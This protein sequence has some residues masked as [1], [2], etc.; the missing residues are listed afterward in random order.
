MQTAR[1]WDS[2]KEALIKVLA[3]FKPKTVLEWGPGVSTLIMQDFP[4][5][6][7]IDT[8]E[9]NPAWWA[10]WKDKFGTKVK[11]Y[12]EENLRNYPYVY[13]GEFKYDLIFVDG[14][15]RE[16][17]LVVAQG[18]IKEDGIVILHDAERESYKS[19]IDN[20]QFVFY[21]DDGH[22]SIMTKSVESN[23]RLERIFES[24]YSSK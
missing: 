9:H 15:D 14:K 18:L 1:S 13:R 4:S 3:E 12:L 10:K 16:S 21:E 20:F 19:F 6:K 22:T 23:N 8:V 11:L 24:S 17:C 5:V 7:L 2:Y